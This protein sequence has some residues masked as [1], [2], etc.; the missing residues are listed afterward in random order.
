MELGAF[1][2][3]M[4]IA[5]TEFRYQVE[6]DIKPFRDVLLG[7]FFVTIGMR[8]DPGVVL[9]EWP[10]LVCLVLV[11]L[12]IKMGLVVGICRAL[13]DDA[14]VAVRTGVW[15]SQ[16]GE[17]AF[18]LFAQA[19]GVGVLGHEGAQ[20]LLAAVL[21]SM[22]SSPLL[23]A[24]VNR[25]TRLLAGQQDWMQRSL[26]L[27][28]V[29]SRSLIRRGHVILCGFGRCGQSLAHVLESEQVIYVA[30]DTDPDRVREAA[31]AGEDVVF[32]DGARRE[33]LLAAGIHRAR[34]L[35]ITFDDVSQAIRVLARVRELAP[36]LP[37]IVRTSNDA[38]IDRLR[39]AGATEVV[40]EIVEGSLTIASHAMGLAGVPAGR[41]R[42]RLRS[43]RA[44]R[45]ALLQG[46]FQGSA[47][48]D[49]ET[50]EEEHVHL[51]AVP[52]PAGAAALGRTLEAV[53]ALDV[54]VT[55]LVRGGRRLPDPDAK[56]VI[57]AGDV[58]VLAGLPDRLAAAE[59]WL[60]AQAAGHGNPAV[61]GVRE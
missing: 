3:G 52:I 4:M 59:E 27:Q 15:L 37:V 1:V 11:T 32:G 18:V 30:L 13:G 53:L 51:Q 22:V 35:V 45:Y 8:L 41:I 55:A 33:V 42:R 57:T 23:L 21:L 25:L 61:P 56:T 43:I 39:E 14:P 12:T 6:E 26:A 48:R 54:R 36:Q 2:A 19:L 31:G 29:A 5:E 46:F 38:A 44:G 40:P 50:I 7:L 47:D 16:T 60:L 34:A 10:Q 58:L 20:L 49:H 17:F 24:Q 9:S 28:Q